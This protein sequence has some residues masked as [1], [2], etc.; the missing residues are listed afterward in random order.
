MNNKTA[1]ITGIRGQDGAYLAQLL[2]SKGYHVIGTDRRRVDQNNW[3]LKY[4]GIEDE[5]DIRYM[6]LLEPGNIFRMIRDIKPDEF[7][8]L[9]AQS[10]VGV[11]FEQPLLTAQV[12]ALGPLH[13]LEAIRTVSPHTKFYQAS[14]SEMFGKVHEI[15]Q[16]ENTPLH[17]RSP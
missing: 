1:I 7:Y 16:N 5:V 10:F 17:P 4:L 2:L 14:T 13:I 6:D 9:A 12:D 8:N 15:P 3:R 11:S